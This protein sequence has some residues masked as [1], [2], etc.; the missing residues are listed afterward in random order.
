MRD[1]QYLRGM[2]KNDPEIT[3]EREEAWIG[4]AVLALFARKWIMETDNKMDGDKFMR[5]TSNDFLRRLG[6]PT[7]EEASIGRVYESEGLEAAFA[8]M[9]ERYLPKFIELEK[10]RVKQRL[11]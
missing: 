3:K 1:I 9:E 2:K 4:D 8:Y 10:S 6:N 11:K 7:S 5:F